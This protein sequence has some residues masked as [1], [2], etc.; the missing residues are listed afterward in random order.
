VLSITTTRIIKG[1]LP[2]LYFTKN[3][4]SIEENLAQVQKEKQAA[5]ALRID[6]EKHAEEDKKL[7]E[8]AIEKMNKEKE[9]IMEVALVQPISD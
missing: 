8:Q 3:I 1:I 6:A 7:R 9:E 4:M 5:E 2:I